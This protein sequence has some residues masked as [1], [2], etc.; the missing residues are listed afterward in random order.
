MS[1]ADMRLLMLS[2]VVFGLDVKASGFRTGGR[3]YG[4]FRALHLFLCGDGRIPSQVSWPSISNGFRMLDDFGRQLYSMQ[5]VYSILVL[6][7]ELE[8]LATKKVAE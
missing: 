5:N 2:G 7:L 6:S 4:T 3:W 1:C 8:E